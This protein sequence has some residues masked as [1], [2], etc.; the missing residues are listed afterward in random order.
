M[1]LIRAI[2]YRQICQT[3]YVDTLQ[4]HIQQ[5]TSAF[6]RFEE[7]LVL[8][9]PHCARTGGFSISVAALVAAFRMSVFSRKWLCIMHKILFVYTAIT[10]LLFCLLWLS[11]SGISCAALLSIIRDESFGL[12]CK[13]EM[14]LHYFQLFWLAVG[15]HRECHVEFRPKPFPS[16][17][18][19]CSY[20]ISVGIRK[21]KLKTMEIKSIVRNVRNVFMTF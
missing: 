5:C 12:K 21:D 15:H 4:M 14:S 19:S 3:H 13:I 16:E 11:R 10:W 1:H 8:C 7:F 9:P 17:P 2:G 20:I 6:N 18:C